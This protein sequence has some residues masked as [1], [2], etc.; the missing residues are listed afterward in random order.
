MTD[1]SKTLANL[2]KTN[3][4][5]FKSDAQAQ[6]VQSIA[7]VEYVSGGSMHGNSYTM[8]Y[9]IDSLGVTAVRK[10]TVAKGLVLVWE[11]VSADKT[12]IQD[13]KEIKRLTRLI[14]TIQKSIDERQASW[15]SGEYVAQSNSF[16]AA[17]MLFGS[18]Q[19]V[20]MNRIEN[21]KIALAALTLK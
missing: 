18:M 12:S 10:S 21:A 15:D 14:K 16:A 17:K 11:R 6:F 1:L 8:F 9:S 20:D 3:N 19:I 13:A 4:G 5:L 2:V 7:G